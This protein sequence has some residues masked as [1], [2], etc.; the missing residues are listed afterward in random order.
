M[1]CPSDFFSVS[2]LL[3]PSIF[4]M[5][6]SNNSLPFTPSHFFFPLILSFLFLDLYQYSFLSSTLDWLVFPLNPTSLLLSPP[7]FYLLISSYPSPNESYLL[8]WEYSPFISN[9]FSVPSTPPHSILYLSPVIFS[10]SVTSR[11]PLLFVFLLKRI[12][13]FKY[14][15]AFFPSTHTFHMWFPGVLHP[16]SITVPHKLTRDT[17]MCTTNSA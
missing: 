12:S 15:K 3:S 4:S 13:C 10:S 9:S 14:W 17:T 11:P 7:Y 8:S 2:S 1:L 5:A 16:T 6:T